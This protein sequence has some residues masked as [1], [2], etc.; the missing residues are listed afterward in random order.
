MARVLS[1]LARYCMIKMVLLITGK[2]WA[3]KLLKR[4]RKGKNSKLDETIMVYNSKVTVRTSKSEAFGVT[5]SQ[6]SLS[7][8]YRMSGYEPT[9]QIIEQGRVKE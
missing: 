6:F 7:K 1:S 4:R 3:K 5:A 2:R 9:R 8:W